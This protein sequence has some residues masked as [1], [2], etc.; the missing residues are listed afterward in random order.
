MITFCDTPGG[1]SSP[2]GS[3]WILDGNKKDA[4]QMAGGKITRYRLRKNDRNY[5]VPIS[6]T[7]LLSRLE[8]YDITPPE[9]IKQVEQL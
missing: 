9:L 6:F 4:L 3:F 8:N 2:R 5:L 7:T 1:A